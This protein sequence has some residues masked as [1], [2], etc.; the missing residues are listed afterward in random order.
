MSRVEGDEK[1]KRIKALL[2]SYSV[3]GP[4]GYAPRGFLS[5]WIYATWVCQNV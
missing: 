4:S 1:E 3:Q 5:R 2:C